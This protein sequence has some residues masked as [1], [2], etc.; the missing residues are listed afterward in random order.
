MA[1]GT[2]G[3]AAL[4][5]YYRSVHS[6][7]GQRARRVTKASRARLGMRWFARLGLGGA[8]PGRAYLPLDRRPEEKRGF[9]MC[10]SVDPGLRDT[11]LGSTCVRS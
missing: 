6:C 5:W 2:V 3:E 1:V 8:R 7:A 4:A 11:L 9:S 10:A